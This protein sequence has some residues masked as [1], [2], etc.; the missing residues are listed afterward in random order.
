M[1][2]PVSVMN[3]NATPKPITTTTV[4]CSIDKITYQGP[5]TIPAGLIN[6]T[7]VGDIQGH[8]GTELVIATLDPGKT[9]KDLQDWSSIDQPP[10]AEWIGS[11]KAPADK[12]NTEMVFVTNGPIYLVCYYETPFTKL[13]AYGPVEV[14]K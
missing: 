9:L 11:V 2:S 3:K 14:G 4:T 7:L 5:E 13:K 8:G 6:I 10:F 1:K 12:P